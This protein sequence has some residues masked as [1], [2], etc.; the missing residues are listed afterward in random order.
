LLW[1]KWRPRQ[2]R[3]LQLEVEPIELRRGDTVRV[4]LT[5]TD[6]RKIGEELDLGL[7]C[8]QYYDYTAVVQD[9]HGSHRERKTM[10]VESTAKWTKPDRS[11]VRQTVQFTVPADAPF[12][13]EGGAVSWAWHVSARDRHPHR[14]D[15]HRTVPVWVSL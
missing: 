9:Q 2:A 15:A 7:V 8:T 12:S 11:Q 1:R 14:Y 10:E 6:A 3:Y 5:I 13:F 4:T